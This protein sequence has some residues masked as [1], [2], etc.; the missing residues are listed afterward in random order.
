MRESMN[1]TK[2]LQALIFGLSYSL[3]QYSSKYAFKQIEEYVLIKRII[4]SLS[5]PTGINIYI[6]ESLMDE[7]KITSKI[8]SIISVEDSLISLSKR[9]QNFKSES[10]LSKLSNI[11]LLL[12]HKVLLNLSAV[13]LIFSFSNK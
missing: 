11:N 1:L 10:Y 4:K 7:L 3:I 2:N 5:I 12:L 13:K 8:K 6:L 9:V